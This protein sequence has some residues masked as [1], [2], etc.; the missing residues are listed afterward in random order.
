MIFCII[1]PT[2]F[3][4][5]CGLKTYCCF[6]MSHHS[7]RWRR[8]RLRGRWEALAP[9]RPRSP[10]SRLMSPSPSAPRSWRT[11]GRGSWSSRASRCPTLASTPARRTLTRPRAKSS[12]SV[13]IA[14]V[15]PFE[16]L[17][18]GKNGNRKKGILFSYLFSI[19]SAKKITMEKWM[20]T[21][22]TRS[23]SRIDNA[24]ALPSDR[25]K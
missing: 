21:A 19:Q 1:F 9:T 18:D 25:W 17:W 13:S 12:F 23:R 14:G 20:S 10:N 6:A 16:Q 11:A 15:P 5:L 24:K 7:R 2:R 4:K 8:R 22:R 3:C